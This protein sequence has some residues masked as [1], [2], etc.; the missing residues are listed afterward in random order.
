MERGWK[1]REE[2]NFEEAE[3]LLNEAKDIFEREGDWFNVTEC[4]NHLAYNKKTQAQNMLTEGYALASES[5]KI[6]KEKGTKNVFA[7][8]AMLSLSDAL[9]VYEEA[10]NYAKETLETFG[11]IADRADILSHIATLELR[12]GDKEKAKETIE[13]ADSLLE[14]TWDESKA[15]HIYIWK[16]RLLG[17]KALI[18]YDLGNIEV[19]K[20]LAE[21]GLQL[22]K[23]KELKTRVK[24]LEHLVNFLSSL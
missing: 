3:K 23:E 1:T 12:A 2:H 5:L 9:G 22:A 11:E 6:A 20:K 17:A 4:L 8:R 13:E 24:Q 7:N 16:T 18:E 14:K 10:I 15:P 21:D 19:A